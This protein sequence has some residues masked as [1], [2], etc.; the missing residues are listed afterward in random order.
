MGADISVLIALSVFSCFAIGFTF[1]ILWGHS[2]GIPF[3][4]KK[5]FRWSIGI[6]AGNSPFDLST[7]DNLKNPVITARDITDVT[8]DFVADPFMIRENNKWH[9]FFEVMT[10]KGEIGLA[11]SSDGLHWDYRQIV[12]REPFHLSYP[13]VFKWNDDYYMIPEANQTEMRLLFSFRRDGGCLPHYHAM[14]S[15]YIMLKHYSAPGFF[16][17]RVQLLGVIT[18][19]QDL[20]E[21][22]FSTRTKSSDSHRMTA[23]TTETACLL[24]KYPRSLQQVTRSEK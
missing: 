14:F 7:P 10:R 18:R 4:Q 2:R 19:E 1:G 24:L 16:I 5:D 20:R 23:G 21:G 8:A 13:Y 3:F 9:M 6:Y 15:F 12:L 11:Q 22:S 17:L